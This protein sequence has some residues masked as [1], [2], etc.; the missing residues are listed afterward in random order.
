MN[1]K[2]KKLE[3][4]HELELKNYLMV[5][6]HGA[7]EYFKSKSETNN[8]QYNREMKLFLKE[9]HSVKKRLFDECNK[10]F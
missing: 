4:A 3:E 1:G 2:I 8:A 9:H 5:A 7:N 10:N 6:K